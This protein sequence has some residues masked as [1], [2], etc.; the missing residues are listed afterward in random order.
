MRN[1]YEDV[2]RVLVTAGVLA[3]AALAAACSTDNLLQAAHPDLINPGDIQS[4]DGANALRL[5]AMRRWV[6]TTAGPNSN[7][8]ESTWLFGGL[9][10]DEWGTSSTFVQNDQV[11]ERRATS[12]NTTVTN[13]FRSL[14]RVR[15]AVNQALP[16]MRQ[17]RPTEATNIAELYFARAFAEMQLASDFC[18][19]IPLS[20][21]ANPDGSISY[22]NPLSVDSV[23]KIAISTA[24]SGIALATASDTATV[25]ILNGLRV[26]KARAQMGLDL[27][28]AA[29]AT[30]NLVPTTSVYNH[31]FSLSTATIGANGIWGQPMS[32]RRYL[33]GDS[34]EGNARNLLVANAIPF[35]SANDP[36]L[37]AKFTVTVTGTRTDT[38]KSQDGL[39]N[40]RT[41]T[42]YDQTTSVAVTSGL[43]ARLIEAE[44]ALAAGN[45]NGANGMIPILNTLRGTRFQLG[46][47]QSPVMPPLA[48]PGTP[49]GR[50]DLLFREKAFWTFT[51]GQ[52]L[53]DMRRLVRY[54]G[55]AVTS[56]YPEGVHY[57]GGTYGTDVTLL[58]P[59]EEQNNPNFKGCTDFKP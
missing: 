54:Y 25:N 1:R 55:R 48:D 52:R 14:N 40:S 19:G 3:Y 46:T 35:F 51:R 43:D 10:V 4:P 15:T 57:R 23:F 12:D 11:D 16:L 49:A 18:N 33:V 53:E 5:G 28:A 22:G 24:D 20:D 56:V 38:T 41:T 32:N 21:A 7:G 37:P 29:A 26:I 13:A 42:L 50:I 59:Q 17:F 30:A 39:T 27:K 44:A 31:T 9:L 2:R 58:I 8:N 6:A 34:V 45:V 36:R 47:V